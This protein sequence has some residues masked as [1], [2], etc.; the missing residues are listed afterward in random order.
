PDLGGVINVVLFIDPKVTGAATNVRHDPWRD[1]VEVV[2]DVDHPAVF[3]LGG[4][5][6][7][8]SG[9]VSGQSADVVVAVVAFGFETEAIAEAPA[10]RDDANKSGAALKVGRRR[11]VA[12]ES[13]P[14]RRERN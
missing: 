4:A 6:A 11:V 2:E 3:L 1:A 8:A 5:A 12:N 10:E 9:G 7:D 14:E 13:R